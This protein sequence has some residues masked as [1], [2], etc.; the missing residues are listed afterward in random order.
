VYKILLEIT[1]EAIAF[2]LLFDFYSRQFEVKAGKMLNIFKTAQR[3]VRY[4]NYAYSEFLFETNMSLIY[5]GI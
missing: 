1:F 2:I 5:C 4:L 3:V